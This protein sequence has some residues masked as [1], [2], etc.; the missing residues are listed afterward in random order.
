MNKFNVPNTTLYVWAKATVLLTAVK[1]PPQLKHEH[2]VDYYQ[3]LWLVAP[4]KRMFITRIYVAVIPRV[5]PWLTK[6]AEKP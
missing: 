5:I 1:T 6:L 2:N 4:D 3:P